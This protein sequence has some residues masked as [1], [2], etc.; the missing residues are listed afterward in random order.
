[1]RKTISPVNIHRVFLAVVAMICVSSQSSQ[2]S[3]GGSGRKPAADSWDGGA[4]Q[5]WPPSPTDAVLKISGVYP[6]L[7]VYNPYGECGMGAIVPWAGK[8]WIITYPPHRPKG[9]DDKLYTVDDNLKLEIRPESVGGTHANRMVHEESNQLIIGPHFIDAQGNVRTADISNLVARLTSTTRH[10][11]D[12]ANKVFFVGMEK[13]LYE[14]DVHTLAVTRIYDGKNSPFPGT[15][16]K[17]GYVAQG[18]LIV[19]FNGERGWSFKKD[20]HFDG[21]A[22]V[23]AESDGKDWSAP[24]TIV[25]RNNSCEITGPGGIRGHAPGDDRVWSTGWDKRSVLLRLREAGQWHTYRLPKGSYTH[26]ALHGWYTEW[27][28][29]RELMSGTF[30]M[31][32][33]GLFYNFPKTFSAANTGGLRPIST[34]HKMPVDYCWWNNQIVMTRDD[35]SVMD[36]AIAGQSHSNLWFG[37]LDDLKHYGTPTGWGGPWLNDAVKAGEP[38]APFLVAGF[39]Q[40][41][42]HLRN[43]SDV[44]V[45]FAIEADAD[46]R[47]HWKK[48]ATVAVAANGY[49]WWPLPAGLEA[50]WLRLVTDRDATG[51]TAYFHLGNPPRKPEPSLFNALADIGMS[52]PLSDGII[53]PAQGDARKLIFAAN[54][55]QADGAVKETGFYEIGG[56]F[57]LRRADNPGRE[58]ILREKFGVK[59][60]G[61]SVDAASVIVTWGG[62]RFRLP[63]SAAACDATPASGWPRALRE[64]VTERNLFNAHG[65]FYEVPRPDGG[66]FRKMGPLTTHNKRISDFC[67]WRG[68]F[69]LAGVS[70]Q[71]AADGHCFRSDDGKTALW[72]GEV[73]DLWRMGAPRGTGG[74]WK[75]T[76]ITA[77]TPSDPYLMTGYNH[78]TL[79]LSHDAKEPVTFTVEVDFLADGSWSEYARFTVEP[80]KPLQ[81][82]FPE[83]YSAH[84]VRLRADRAVKATAT[85]TYTA[86]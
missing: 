7:T 75:E 53:K 64:V 39:H 14:V 66:G 30:L 13:E 73:D 12:P 33:H 72:F 36:N 56:E 20:P 71:A 25:G 8:L 60:A 37:Q 48:T 38:S 57:K 81:H 76:A 63:K 86:N 52:G 29:I 59:S 3:P 28:R 62:E 5:T 16:G 68:L 54:V 65:T 46:G 82:V 32:M 11:T 61:F 34:Y 44:P 42:L 51:V 22:G 23:L 10:L 69:V 80:G 26:D 78:K 77:D 58:K 74:P 50:S 55:H 83:G 47:G 43:A 27:P 21:P 31:H 9:S 6:H 35:A 24:W 41:V 45:E 18:R 1:M 85:F 15:H 19:A 40:S 84:W 2:P 17:G 67:S 49:K 4:G 79:E 70:A